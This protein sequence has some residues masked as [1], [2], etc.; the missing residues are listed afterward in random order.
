MPNSDPYQAYSYDT[1]HTDDGGKWGRHLW[2]LL[3]KVLDEEMGVLGE[4]A[5]K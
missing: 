1:L 5:T 3:K 4:L 2:V